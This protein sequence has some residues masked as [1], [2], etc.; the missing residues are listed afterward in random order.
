MREPIGLR[1]RKKRETRIALSAAT[2]RLGVERGWANVTIED[3]AAAA[4]V[5]VRTFRNYFSSKAE[6]VASRHVAR[7]EQV[8]AELRR[9]PSEEPLWEAISAAVRDRF[10]LG[11]DT[12]ADAPGD[13]RWAEGIRRILAE[14]AVQAAVLAASA[15]AQ[16]ALAAAIAERTGTDAVEDLYPKLVAGAVGAACSVAIEHGLSTDPPLAVLPLLD[17]A[18]E[19]LAAGLPVPK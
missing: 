3:I 11:A 1:E 16:H 12:D 2:I 7:M 15:T 19:Q 6:A 8:A 5:S 14:P 9:R 10:A 4:D 18:L 17:D 13:R